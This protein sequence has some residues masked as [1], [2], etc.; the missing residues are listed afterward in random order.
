MAIRLNRFLAEAGLGSRRGVESL[1]RDGRVSINGVR[2]LE[3][4]TRV[5]PE[6][7]RVEVDGRVVGGRA[8][9]R[10]LMYNKPAGVICSFQ[11]QG[12]TK[13]LT[14]TL[15]PALRSGRLFHIGRLDKDTTGLLLLGNEGDLAHALTHPRQAL[16][17]RYRV[18][19]E[20]RLDE[21]QFTQIRDGKLALDGKPCLPARIRQGKSAAGETEYE[22][23]L[24]EGRNRQIRRIFELFGIRVRTLHRSGFGPLGLGGLETGAWRELRPEEAES[25]RQAAGL[26]SD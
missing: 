23:Q 21:T 9:L 2:I 19:V 12:R 25:L 10:L 26:T 20:G 13:C 1:V 14:D 5:D 6:S 7:D 16:W 24:R 4:G 15:E 8:A 18:R 3:L 11:R 17:K 22:I